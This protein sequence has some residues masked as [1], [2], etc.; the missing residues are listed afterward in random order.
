[1]ITSVLYKNKVFSPKTIIG[2]LGGAKSKLLAVTNEINEEMGIN[3]DL[4]KPYK[5]R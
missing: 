1:M 3:N 4:G 5:V 2:P